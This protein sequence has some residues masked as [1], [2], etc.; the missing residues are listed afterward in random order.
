MDDDTVIVR[1]NSPRFKLLL[2]GD[3]L[4]TLT[5]SILFHHEMSAPFRLNVSRLCVLL[6]ALNLPLAAQQRSSLH[7]TVDNGLSQNS[8]YC[9]V[10][11]RDGF[12]WI[13]TA[14]GLDRYDGSEIVAFVHSP[15]DPQSLRHNTVRALAVGGDG[16]LYVG[17][18][19]GL[20]RFDPVHHT[21]EHLTPYLTERLFRLSDGSLISAGGGQVYQFFPTTNSGRWFD[22]LH[23]NLP[24]RAA[25]RAIAEDDRGGLWFGM[26]DGLERYDPAT[27]QYERFDALLTSAGWTGEKDIR[28]LHMD[29]EGILWI[30]SQAAGLWSLDPRTRTLRSFRETA[31]GGLRL[32]QEPIIGI[33]EDA[34]GDL[35]L[36]SGHSG[37]LHYTRS[38]GKVRSEERM[39]QEMRAAGIRTIVAVTMDRSGLLWTST[40]GTGVYRAD[41]HPERFRMVEGTEGKFIKSITEGNDGNIWIGTYEQ[42]MMRYDPKQGTT[43][44]Y[45]ISVVNDTALASTV[46]CLHRGPDGRTWIG[47]GEGL[48]SFDPRTGKTVPVLRRAGSDLPLLSPVYAIAEFRGLMWC[49]TSDGYA[50][51]DP[52]RNIF[53]SRVTTVERPD[54]LI[55]NRVTTMITDRE[56]RLWIGTRGGGAALL[57]TSGAVLRTYRKDDLEGNAV[58]TGIRPQPDGTTF[59]TTANGAFV[60]ARDG[61]VQPICGE[62]GSISGYCYGV[63]RDRRGDLWISTN[64]G[65]LRCSPGEGTT[66]RHRRYGSVDGL[67]SNEFNSNAFC[68]TADGHFYFG[69]IAGVSFFHPDSVA[70]NPNV[71]PVVITGIRSEEEAA[72]RTPGMVMG[73]DSVIELLYDGPA[74]LVK[75]AALEYTN[76]AKNR[77]AYRIE[78]FEPTVVPLGAQKQLRLAHLPPGTYR[79]E[80][81]ACNNDGVWNRTGA[82]LRF[83]VVPPWW[84]TWQAK[85]SGIAML[86]GV[87]VLFVRR[88]ERKRQR[89][90][91][92]R[93][94][95]QHELELER[96]RI[97]K[98]MHDEVG[99]SLTKIA[100]LSDLAR[101]RS[102][103]EQREHL[104]RISVTARDVIDNVGQIIWALDPKHDTLDDLLAYIREYTAEHLEL[105]GIDVRFDLPDTVP[106]CV[107]SSAFR[108]NMFLTVK[109]AVNNCAKYS[110]AASASLVITCTDRE[111]A[112]AFSDDGAGFDATAV[113]RF[114]NGLLNMRKRVEDLHGSIHIESA[115]GAGTRIEFLLPIT[116]FV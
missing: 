11:D 82:S 3:K 113:G 98:D 53:L 6:V 103:E 62:E 41:P 105:A 88:W 4:G 35:W 95:R 40:D 1:K 76:S 21:F 38:D 70:D 100:M 20:D 56:G 77:Y 12:I 108:R 27:K 85:G 83:R 114:G 32:L 48:R 99:S 2:G 51:F 61:R 16:R 73:K 72:W 91:I 42:G 9:V 111:I 24:E 107:L 63:L 79:L 50:L 71:P 92:D 104:E 59:L 33:C 43:R 26:T 97:S 115:P 93:M 22:S 90:T 10:Q 52:V 68:R 110:R 13:G 81:T 46:Y 65:I 54:I 8:A 84:M 86:I 66:R 69:G 49:G 96:A 28:S 14:D 47:T 45:K 30:G 23:F 75:F 87:I 94:R 80:V 109:E 78:G 17:T 116:T 31:D 101:R 102:P 7:I 39:L 5:H 58:V 15:S 55:D 74:L 36:G 67:Q 106:Q 57:D 112:V 44:H 60:I 29:R 34:A 64:R 19:E 89:K 25:V 37:L 18:D